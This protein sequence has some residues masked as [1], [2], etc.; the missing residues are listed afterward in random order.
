MSEDGMSTGPIDV[1]AVRRDDAFIDDLAAGRAADVGDAAEYQLA[2]LLA[3]WRTESL[4][5]PVPETPTIADIETAIVRANERERRGG[6]S[7]RLRIVSGAAAILA[8]VGAG[9]LVLSEGSN[10]GDPLWSVKQVVFADQAQQTQSRLNAQENIAEAKKALA[11]GDTVKARELIAKAEKDIGPIRDKNEVDQLRGL[12]DEIRKQDPSRLIPSLPSLPNPSEST[13]PP[14]TSDTPNPTVL[15]ETPPSSTTTPS[16]TP[17][18]TTKSTP[19]TTKSETEKP[20][21]STASATT[22]AS[23]SS[24]TVR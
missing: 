9:V 21:S 18:S 20:S 10:P 17:P 16:K 4:S 15:M 7:R 24:S 13:T 5:G 19:S 11:A 6:L 23:P 2:G 12:I 14:V 8:V 22:T 3:Q 1:G